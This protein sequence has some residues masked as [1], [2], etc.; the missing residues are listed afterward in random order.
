MWSC[1]GSGGNAWLFDKEEML[2][3]VNQY[4]V[5]TH[6]VF[7]YTKMEELVLKEK[8]AGQN[9]RIRSYMS[10]LPQAGYD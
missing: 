3:Q 5:D 1:R 9:Y 10:S 2:S 6:A 4:H 8:M 7:L